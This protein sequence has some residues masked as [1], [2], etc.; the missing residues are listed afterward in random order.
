MRIGGYEL[1]K[2][3]HRGAEMVVALARRA[4]AHGKP[5]FV[6][7]RFTPLSTFDNPEEARREAESYLEICRLQQRVATG[8]GKHWAPVHECGL[9]DPQQA[10]AYAV[11]DFYPRSLDKYIAGRAKLS[12]DVLYVIL[13]AILTGLKEFEQAAHRAHGALTPG[14]VLFS[15]LKKVSG[16]RILLTDPALRA[17][18]APR[19]PYDVGCIIYEFVFNR[20]YTSSVGY[21]LRPSPEWQRLG[22]KS[23]KWRDFCSR[24]LNPRGSPTLDDVMRAAQALKPS[25]AKKIFRGVGLALAAAV[26]ILAAVCNIPGADKYPVAGPLKQQVLASKEKALAWWTGIS[27]DE[28]NQAWRELCQHYAG[29]FGPLFTAIPADRRARWLQDATLRNVLEE[30]DRATKEGTEFDPRRIAKAPSTLVAYLKDQ[31]PKEI[32]TPEA[33]A[34]IQEA[35]VVMNQ[36]HK[37]LAADQWP[38]R[39][40]LLALS[41]EYRQRGWFKVS[42]YLAQQESRLPGQGG[43]SD[44]VVVDEV[45]ALVPMLENMEEKWRE[46]EGLPRRDQLTAAMVRL[47]E[48]ASATNARGT[49]ADLIFMR[50]ILLASP[51]VK[52]PGVTITTPVVEETIKE[53]P[54]KE[55]VIEEI[56]EEQ[57]QR[58]ALAAELSAQRE[59]SWTGSEVIDE[60]WR[61]QCL[62]IL[63]QTNSHTIL[64]GEAK[65]LRT[66]LEDM[67]W[68]LA[69]DAPGGSPDEPTR[70]DVWTHREELLRQLLDSTLNKNPTPQQSA[71]EYLSKSKGADLVHAYDQWRRELARKLE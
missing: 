50:E 26:I 7:K 17:P 15:S 53:T 54:V 71:T 51:S 63:S 62:A 45:L 38:T 60:A 46:T 11:T 6:I 25:L 21:P 12:G 58:E 36:I 19:D 27:V 56:S 43:R 16:A 2:E 49:R 32:K 13:M 20:P 40:R 22:G 61:Q 14:K 47:N 41:D 48:G 66:F 35:L 9:V 70:S 42:S 65:Q 23:E 67:D 52:E 18:D 31:P 57:R 29:W 44:T 3:L 30:I 1:D 34:R 33:A 55:K 28:Q 24:L 4:G 10:E 69:L 39:A 37:Q 64:R 68:L 5:Q 8:S 59:I